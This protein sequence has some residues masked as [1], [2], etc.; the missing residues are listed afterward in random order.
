MMG[1]KIGEVSPSFLGRLVDLRRDVIRSISLQISTDWILIGFV[2][3]A[4]EQKQPSPNSWEYTTLLL[5]LLPVQQQQA[6][7]KRE[8]HEVW[9]VTNHRDL[10]F[11]SFP[12]PSGGRART[13]VLSVLILTNEHA[14]GFWYLYQVGA[15]AQRVYW[16][17]KEAQSGQF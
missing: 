8:S 17:E 5:R 15:F 2:E 11:S 13:A 14:W 3:D 10:F 9:N 16:I 12:L 4:P 1:G 6:K 7:I